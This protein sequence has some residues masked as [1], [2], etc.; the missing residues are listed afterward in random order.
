[1]ASIILRFTSCPEI[2]VTYNDTIAFSSLIPS[3]ALVIVKPFSQNILVTSDNSHIRSLVQ[4]LSLS[5]CKQDALRSS[6]ELEFLNVVDPYGSY[7]LGL[8]CGTKYSYPAGT[9]NPPLDRKWFLADVETYIGER[10]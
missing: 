10:S 3:S 8:Y 4:I 2:F 6:F 5:P 9:G 7:V 1:M